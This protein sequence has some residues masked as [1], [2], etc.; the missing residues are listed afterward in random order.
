ML[1]SESILCFISHCGANSIVEALF[2]AVPI[3]VSHREWRGH[4]GWL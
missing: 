1:T 3:I 4:A 2:A